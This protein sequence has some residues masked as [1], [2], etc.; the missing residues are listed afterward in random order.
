M[1]VPAGFDN[2][3]RVVLPVTAI[4]LNAEISTQNGAGYWLTDIK[5][6]DSSVAALIFVRTNAIYG[7]AA[8]QKINVVNM[9]QPDIDAD[10]AI[11]LPAGYVPTGIFLDPTTPGSIF[12]LYQLLDDPLT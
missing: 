10:A 5:I 6:M 11:E 12:I 2:I 9:D 7:Y 3:V 8:P 1:P 4:D